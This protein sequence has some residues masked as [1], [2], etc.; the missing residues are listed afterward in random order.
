[1]DNESWLG[2]VNRNTHEYVIIGN[3]LAE[4]EPGTFIMHKP[5]ADENKC[6]VTLELQRQHEA[7]TI[8]IVEDVWRG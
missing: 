6:W 5:L 3:Y 8:N 7:K 2:R 1:M 4:H